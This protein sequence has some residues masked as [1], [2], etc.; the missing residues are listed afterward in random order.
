MV[1]QIVCQVYLKEEGLTQ[2]MGDHGTSNSHSPSLN[3]T[4][5]VEGFTKIGWY[6]YSIQLRA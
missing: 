3:I 2:N 4:Y 6:A 5:C 1:Y